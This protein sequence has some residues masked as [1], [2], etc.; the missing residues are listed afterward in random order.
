MTTPKE[1]P[2]KAEKL[3]V[4]LLEDYL[5]DAKLM[6][7]T[8]RKKNPSWEFLHVTDRSG[9]EDALAKQVPDLILSDYSM[10]QYT[11]MEAFLTVQELGLEIP[12]ILVTGELT[13]DKAISCIEEGID[14]YVIKSSLTRLNLAI[15]NALA[16]RQKEIDSQEI[17]QHLLDSESQFRTIFNNAGVAIFEMEFSNIIEIVDNKTQWRKADFEDIQNLF[18]GAAIIEAN[19]NALSLF[20]AKDK[21]EISGAFS[22]LWKSDDISSLRYS[23]RQISKL[24]SWFEEKAHFT[25]IDG[26]KIFLK[27]TFSLIDKVKGRYI[28]SFVDLTDV[29]R[30]EAKLTNVIER[31][32]SVVNSRTEELNTLNDE[33][34]NQA[35]DR[36]R[37]NG[38][39]RE[40]YIHMTESIIAAKRIQQLILPPKQVIADCFSDV[41]IYLRPL[42]IVS[43]DFYWFY[44]HGSKCW[45]ASVDCTGHGVP[46]AFMSMVGSNVLNQAV[47]ESKTEST[48]KILEKIDD[49]VIREM[50]QH[51]QGTE[52]S[53]GMDI[54]LCSFDFAKM[55]MRFSGAFQQ[56]YFIRD[57]ELQIFK[58]DRFSLGGTF[59][60]ERKKFS[61]HIIPIQRDDRLYMTTDGFLDQFG[62]PKN[63][64]FTRKRFMQLIQD[65]KGETM[66]DQE[67]EIKSALQDWKG[68]YEQ[69]DDIL[70]VGIRI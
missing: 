38:M 2:Y 51:E 50:R 22:K 60:H 23:A 14:D 30:S 43:G 67:M 19:D 49:L 42:D 24:S 35:R 58:G 59:K 26:G 45:I 62:G 32:E 46:G 28:V 11:G 70:V 4:L 63:K 31:M 20:Q 10:P 8:I 39:L 9:F 33:L 65:A 53:T 7:K 3:K 40:N 36:E 41:F 17:A 48:S 34:Q 21:E 54:S 55:E 6:T 12:F 68:A 37:I 52:V 56:L 15:H 44:Q 64:K 25:T 61:E 69:I 5:L 13:E 1:R 66:Y 18:E 29:K 27:Y 47:I 16:K 57:G